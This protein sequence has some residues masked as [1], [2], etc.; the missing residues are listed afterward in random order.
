MG[1][2]RGRWLT[3]SARSIQTSAAASPRQVP[4]GCR[5]RRILAVNRCSGLLAPRFGNRPGINGV[6]SE[7]FDDVVDQVPARSGLAGDGESDA[8][9]CAA[10]LSALEQMLPS[11]AVEHLVD[12]CPDLLG[13]PCTLELTVFDRRDLT[14]ALLGRGVLARIPR[15]CRT[16]A[17]HF[18]TWANVTASGGLPGGGTDASQ[19]HNANAAGQTQGRIGRSFSIVWSSNCLRL[20]AFPRRGA[21]PNS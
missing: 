13:N 8:V 20:Q 15:G 19:P 6:E 9:R 21:R 14:V 16:R 3:S 10:G 7:L 17:Q 11:D 1:G 4:Y 5:P 18:R 2:T 12:R